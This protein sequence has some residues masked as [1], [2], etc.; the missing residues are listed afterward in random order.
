MQI[1]KSRIG[2]ILGKHPV[3]STNKSMPKIGVV[4][5]SM[6]DRYYQPNTTHEFNL[7]PDLN[8]SIIKDILEIS[9]KN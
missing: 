7:D 3:S 1:D 8:K 5:V 6:R 4:L 2:E 9:G